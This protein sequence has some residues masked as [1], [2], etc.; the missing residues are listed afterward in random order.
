[1]AFGD[2]RGDAILELVDRRAFAAALVRRHAA[3]RLEQRRYRAALAQ[4][5]NAHGFQCRFVAGGGNAAEDFLFQLR[6]V[7]HGNFVGLC[8]AIWGTPDRDQAAGSAA[9][10]FSTIAWKA[11]GSVMARSESTLRSTVTPALA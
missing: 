1:L 4:R 6:Q 7:G 9:F 5:C 11:A 10:A 2:G 3:E 8:P